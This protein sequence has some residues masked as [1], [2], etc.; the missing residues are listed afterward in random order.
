MGNC[1]ACIS[2]RTTIA[3]GV[4]MVF[5]LAFDPSFQTLIASHDDWSECKMLLR[6]G[7]RWGGSGWGERNESQKEEEEMK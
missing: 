1:I 7:Q 3:L 6:E 2:V 4:R 5:S